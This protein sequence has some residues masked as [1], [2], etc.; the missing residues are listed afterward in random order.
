MSI[1]MKGEKE[2]DIEAKKNFEQLSIH[3]KH[4]WYMTKNR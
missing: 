2:L 4:D 3:F 1:K